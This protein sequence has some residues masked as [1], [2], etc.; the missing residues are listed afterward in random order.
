M[1][2]F[3]I[4]GVWETI[5]RFVE[6]FLGVGLLLI[7]T[8]IFADSLFTGSLKMKLGI[9]TNAKVASDSMRKLQ[10]DE[11]KYYIKP[12]MKPHYHGSAKI[13]YVEPMQYGCHIFD[14]KGQI[15]GIVGSEKSGRDYLR[16]VHKVAS[17]AS[18]TTS[19]HDDYFHDYHP[20][21]RANRGAE[22]SD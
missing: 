11:N 18:T 2:D 9:S 13:G 17:N 20:G 12:S 7:L 6:L 15:K 8:A 22:H 10:P 21:Y 4:G 16:G 5:I 19:A 14:R 1:V 3:G